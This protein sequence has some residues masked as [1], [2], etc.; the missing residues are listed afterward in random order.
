MNDFKIPDPIRDERFS[1]FSQEDRAFLAEFFQRHP[2]VGQNFS[3]YL[4][5]PAQMRP[6]FAKMDTWDTPRTGWVRR[7]IPAPEDVDSHAVDLMFMVPAVL[8]STFAPKI[9]DET[10]IDHVFRM[11][12]LHDFCEAIATDFTPHDKI[13]PE[14]KDRI[15]TL[16]LKVIFEDE[17]YQVGGHLVR[18]YI[19]QETEASHILHDLDK[20]HAVVRAKAYEVQYPEK[21]GIYEEF[22][23]YAATK[24]KTDVGHAFMQRLTDNVEECL[25]EVLSRK[26][27]F[28]Q[29]YID[30]RLGEFETWQE[31]MRAKLAAEENAREGL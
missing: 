11:A 18:Q 22:R 7:D 23:S 2:K 29:A 6:R 12:R 1:R 25:A 20:L 5:L 10:F 30:R 26:E 21:E 3:R 28:Q 31:T 4:E 17:L 8:T 24:L 16:A 19:E 15:E 13:S 9:Y 14:D 27:A